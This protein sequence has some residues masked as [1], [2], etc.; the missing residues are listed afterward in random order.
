MLIHPE[1]SVATWPIK[2]KF[3]DLNVSEF[4]FLLF[5]HITNTIA[6][7]AN[8]HKKIIILVFHK[9]FLKVA[10]DKTV[11]SRL[12]MNYLTFLF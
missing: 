10:T 9:H 2:D 7:F 3:T 12:S 4:L 5:S 1:M 11:Q 6:E 8:L